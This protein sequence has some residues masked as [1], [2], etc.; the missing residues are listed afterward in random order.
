MFHLGTAA[1]CIDLTKNNQSQIEQPVPSETVEKPKRQAQRKATSK[2]ESQENALEEIEAKKPKR[3]TKRTKTSVSDGAD[4]PEAA[5]TIET[6]QSTEAPSTSGRRA[7]NNSQNQPQPKSDTVE[8]DA[9]SSEQQ[10]AKKPKR[11]RPKKNVDE[12]VVED[13][14]NVSEMPPKRRKVRA[15][16]ASNSED[17]AKASNETAKTKAKITVKP[18]IIEVDEEPAPPKRAR[19][20]K[21]KDTAI[22]STSK[23]SVEEKPAAKKA[24]KVAAT[25]DEHLAR[26]S[27]VSTR[28]RRHK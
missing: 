11:G 8:T 10:V 24:K 6:T 16:S 18:D 25:N 19:T 26:I 17:N 4:Q 14:P 22:E 13:K 23:D 5:V 20:R 28:T 2:K 3:M 9:D 15:P 12:N 7:R 27:P 1:E 21:A